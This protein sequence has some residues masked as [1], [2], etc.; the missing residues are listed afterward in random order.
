MPPPV[1]LDPA[2]LRD[3]PC[4]VSKSGIGELNPHRHEFALLDGIVHKDLP[5][6]IIAGYMDVR[7][8]DW[9]VRGHI[10]GR[11]LLPGVLMIEAAAQL[12][13]FGTKLLGPD[14]V[15][16]VGFGGLEQVKFRETVEP[17]ARL[18]IVARVR[19]LRPR[20]TIWDT[21]GFVGTKMA[22]EAVIIG[23]RV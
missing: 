8:D 17:P 9:W 16:F 2:T 18:L 10:P 6:G 7:T 15:G 11:P 23:M 1:I 22:F 19:E 3:A 20:R 13:S 21:Q 14:E 5:S 4:L 12:A